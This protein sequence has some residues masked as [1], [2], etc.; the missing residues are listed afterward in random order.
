WMRAAGALVPDAGPQVLGDDVEAGLFVMEY[1]EPD[2]YP[3]WK[4]E[5]RAGRADPDVAAEV[6]T[7]LAA[8][9]AGTAADDEVAHRFASDDI[10]WA[11][12]LEPYLLAT[13]QAH[14]DLAQELERLAAVTAS[15]KRCLV[16][17]GMSPKNILV[18]PHGPVFLDAECAWYGE[19]A[20]DAAFCLNH[21]SP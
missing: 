21:R 20:F 17:G 4:A 18:G 6:G 16:H 13:A 14:S 8:I 10:F 11:I 5:L 3:V 9:H 1:L 15:T 2:R 19:P 7:R 12:R